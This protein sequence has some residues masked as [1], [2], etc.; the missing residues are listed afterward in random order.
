MADTARDNEALAYA[1]QRGALDLEHICNA[2]YWIGP[3][4]KLDP[5]TS[6]D[7]LI[8]NLQNVID[9]L[10]RIQAVLRAEMANPSMDVVAMLRHEHVDEAADEAT[11]RE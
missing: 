4:G 10:Q 3:N 11:D 5:R 2:V 1:I 7:L 8:A 6:N 9:D